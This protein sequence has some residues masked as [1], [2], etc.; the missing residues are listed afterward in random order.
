LVLWP[1]AGWQKLET[2][3][4]ASEMPNCHNERNLVNETGPPN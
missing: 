1:V 2:L 4:G 3:T